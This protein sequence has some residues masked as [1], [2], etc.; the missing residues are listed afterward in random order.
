MQEGVGIAVHVILDAVAQD[1]GGG[2]LIQPVRRSQQRFLAAAL[3]QRALDRRR[4]RARLGP[5][6][7]GVQQL[8]RLAGRFL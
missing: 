4:A 1:A 7:G 6:R 8:M 5:L 2:E 3:A